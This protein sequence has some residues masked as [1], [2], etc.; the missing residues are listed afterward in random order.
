MKEQLDKAYINKLIYALNKVILNDTR[1]CFDEKKVVNLINILECIDSEIEPQTVGFGFMI[2]A[3]EF[4][5]K[6]Y[7]KEFANDFNSLIVKNRDHIKLFVNMFDSKSFFN[8][9]KLKIDDTL[10]VFIKACLSGD[11]NP[12]EVLLEPENYTY[13]W[14]F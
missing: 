11:K 1:Y 9:M 4:S 2:A 5:S 8:Y 6:K 10:N 14:K 13:I 3:T 12:I 7:Q